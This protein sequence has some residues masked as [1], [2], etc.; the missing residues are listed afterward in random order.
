MARSV[1]CIWRDEEGMTT[2]GMAVSIMLCLTLIFSGAQLYRVESAS[3][4]IQEV[5]DVAALAAESEVAEFMIAVKL[6]DAAVL[7]MTL[8]S[9][10]VYGIGIVCAC[11]PPLAA[12][13]EQLISLAGQVR[14]ACERFYDAAVN[15]LNSLQKALPFL[16]AASA[17]SVAAANNDGA[18]DADYLALAVLVPH[19]GVPIGSISS[20]DL[21]ELGNKAEGSAQEIREDSAAIEEAARRANEAKERGYLADCG[22]AASGGEGGKCMLERASHLASLSGASNPMYASVDAWSFDVAV[23][24]AKAYYQK[25]R[26]SVL[27]AGASSPKE[28]ANLHCR[29]AYYGYALTE[30]ADASLHT[31]AGGSGEEVSGSI[32]RLFRKTSELRGS[33]AY[34]AVQFPVSTA[35]NVMHGYAACPGIAGS[36]VQMRPVSYCDADGAP[37]CPACEFTVES[38]GEVGNA[39]SRVATGFEYHYENMRQASEDY[40]A[41]MNELAPLKAA[42]KGK[43]DPVMDAVGNV[44][45]NVSAKRI[46]AEPPGRGGVIVMMVN[47]AR[48]AADTGFESLFVGGGTTLG[49]RAAVSAASLV[50]DGAHD[51]GNVITSL[52]DGFGGDGGAAVGAARVVLDCWSGLLRVYE[53]GQEALFGALEDGL[54]SISL[55]SL[56]G[57]GEWASDK[58]K[59]VV[60][61]AGLAPANLNAL[62]PALLNTAHVASSDSGSFAVNFK[63]AKTSALSASAPATGLFPGLST[64]LSDAATNAVSGAKITIAEIEFP[65]GGKKIPIELTLPPEA[66][67]AA[68]GLVGRCIDAVGSAV[69]SITGVRSWQ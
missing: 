37:R 13:S 46:S 52:L 67:E 7:S 19:E 50:E 41:A 69:S 47:T 20:D 28:K 53:D 38:F 39:S 29:Y 25:R 49:M 15:G 17:A 31:G 62:K 51:N 64:A 66:G 42:V 22:N 10:T 54:G 27:S 18:M 56:G 43:V 58:L 3:A 24:R 60:E 14:Q 1:R 34:S 45:A 33:W 11:V 4:E 63:Q 6:C 57:L 8:L 61:S 48:N 2:V 40:K 23:A 44:V 65:V 26:A 21:A 55:G 12:L 68:G 36:A 30:L 32:P 5:A 35:D 16:A 9:A 59:E